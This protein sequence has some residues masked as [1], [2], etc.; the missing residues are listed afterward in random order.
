M[1]WQFI[2]NT[3]DKYE[4]ST[5]KQ[6][7]NT[8]TQHILKPNSINKIRLSTSPPIYESVDNLFKLTFPDQEIPYPSTYLTPAQKLFQSMKNENC[9]PISDYQGYNKPIYYLFDNLEY[10][11]TPSK[12]NKGKR[13][14]TQ[15]CI[16]YTQNH[17]AE[18]FARENCILLS[19]YKN[20]KS[21]LTYKFNDS[22]Y[23]VRFDNW[24]YLNS[25]PHKN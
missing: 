18:L 1:T 22:T 2:P 21:I 24:L 6:I 7:R 11:T 3:N 17:V 25:R 12:W 15:K 20:I 16:Q 23:S 4:M 9:T 10:K 13:A 14:H 19:P 5:D 8:K